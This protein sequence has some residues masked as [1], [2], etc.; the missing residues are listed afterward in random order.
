LF[1]GAIRVESDAKEGFAVPTRYRDALLPEGARWF[2]PLTPIAVCFS[3]HGVAWEPIGAKVQEALQLQRTTR[4]WQRLLWDFAEELEA[5]CSRRILVSP[6]AA[7]SAGLKK[8]RDA[9]GQGSHFEDLGRRIVDERLAQSPHA[10]G[11]NPPP[12]TEKLLAVSVDAHLA[13]PPPPASRCAGDRIKRGGTFRGRDVSAGR[14]QPV[15]S[16]A[17]GPEAG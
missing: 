12:G 11:T 9:G 6:A 4:W 3:I 15:D 14:S 2:S 5:R 8:D 1:Q 13:R 10:S 17:A 16:G 7:K